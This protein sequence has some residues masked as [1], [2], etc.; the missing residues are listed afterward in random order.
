MTSQNAN[1]GSVFVNLKLDKKGFNSSV[2]NS[3]KNTENQFSSSIS[4]GKL[5][6]SIKKL[7]SA[8]AGAF[9]VKKV[10]DFGKSCIDLGSD[11]AEVQNVV[12]VA[13]GSMSKKADEWAKNAI[14]DFGLSETVAKRYLGVFGSMATSFGYT[15][16]QALDMSEKITGLVGDVAS[17]YNLSS[18]ESYTKLKSIFTGETES[19]KDLGVVMTQSALDQYALANG[20]GKTTSAMTEQEKVALRYQFVQDKLSNAAGDFVR[21][22]D[23]WANQTRVLSLRW[24][25]LKASL[26]QG[27]INV[28]TPV[29]KLVNN[30]IAKLQIMADAFKSV[31]ERIFGDAGSAD[32]NVSSIGS[33]ADVTASSV[34][35]IGASADKTADKIK[36]MKKAFGKSDE[37]NIMNFDNSTSTD[38]AAGSGIDTSAVSALNK[39]LDKESETIDKI[40][41]SLERIKNLFSEGITNGLGDFDAEAFSDKLV[42]IKDNIKDIFT[43]ADVVSSMNAF[44]ASAE[45]L[46]TSVVSSTV[47]IGTTIADNIVSGADKYFSE[48][49]EYIQNK[50]AGIFDASAKINDIAADFLDAF[51]NVF[52]VFRGENANNCTA[53]IIGIFSDGFLGVT[54]LASKFSA[55][56]VE[57]ITGPFIDNQD[58]IK[59]S[60]DDFLKPVSTVL[61]TLHDGVKDSFEYFSDVYDRKID[62]AITGIK[63]GFSSLGST[64]IDNWNKYLNPVLNKLSTKFK[65]VWEKHIQP[66][67]DKVSELI[68]SISECVSAFWQ[69]VCVPV[70]NWLQNKLSPIIS[71][72]VEKIG[73]KLLD[74]LSNASDII[75]AFADDLSGAFDW[76]TK[77]FSGEWKTSLS[78]KFNDTKESLSKKW[79]DITSS[80]QLK[81]GKISAEFTNTKTDIKNKWNNITSEIKLKTGKINAKFNQSKTNLTDKWNSLTSGLKEKSVNIKAKLSTVVGSV[82]NFVN[83][84]IESINK[85]L[86]A[87]LSFSFKMPDFLGGKKWSWSAPKIPKLYTG[88]YLKAN[89]PQLA[90]VGDNR[91]EGE[92][93]A[94]ESKLETAVKKAMDSYDNSSR[95]SS[96]KLIIEIHVIG[97]DGKKIIKKINDAQMASGKVLL[98]I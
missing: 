73:S 36:K 38:S 88:A 3:I 76:L 52:M 47:T 90:W 78:V 26:G 46:F 4:S 2:A 48:S 43:S 44:E 28:L 59:K 9:A 51:S 23:S 62:P 40:A 18:D 97:E 45:R 83:Q 65:N 60:I 39:A 33:S 13:F 79:T 41:G 14:T 57:L 70:F 22:Q 66:A 91:T 82:K 56:V 63:D 93:V 80:I 85:N 19:L 10:V 27:F 84:L 61:S 55:S 42:N 87:K 16:D 29:L 6:S 54:E 58:K 53:E 31:T 71:W 98:K 50:I 74:A 37:L 95:G 89:N 24:D 1:V 67:L 32:S 64:F 15:T 11:L 68:G 96:N 12:D 72:I 30:I 34:D 7:T 77:V 35:N 8:F 69:G 75:G 21:T 92:F 25:S 49:K 20:F 94:P 86:I 81:K 17:F 5:G